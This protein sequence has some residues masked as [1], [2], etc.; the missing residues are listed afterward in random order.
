MNLKSS[1][2]RRAWFRNPFRTPSRLL[3]AL[4]FL[5]AAWT[6]GPLLN[7]LPAFAAKRKAGRDRPAKTKISDRLKA[8]LQDLE[9]LSPP[10]RA[11]AAKSI[12]GLDNE[13]L[14][15]L[16]ALLKHAKSDS[17]EEVRRASVDG[18]GTLGAKAS[19]AVPDLIA[20]L[21]DRSASSGLKWSVVEALS[22][23]GPAASQATDVLV[24]TLKGADTILDEFVATAL[25][26]INLPKAVRALVR[27]CDPDDEWSKEKMVGAM[28]NLEGKNR[29]S[30][31]E[32]LRQALESPDSQ[33]RARAAFV[34]GELKAGWAASDLKKLKKKDPAPDVQK[35]AESALEKI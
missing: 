13:G 30:T 15:A 4:A 7:P 32:A 2:R 5:G 29:D 18:I 19:S 12:G 34:L 21:K 17:E 11:S 16:P 24:D 23:M 28:R 31:R 20:L 33:I 25:Y 10:T 1:S 6:L 26:K 22:R 14:E 27:E 8:L 35:H 9:H 3:A